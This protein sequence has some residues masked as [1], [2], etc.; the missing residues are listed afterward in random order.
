LNKAILHKSI[1]LLS[2][3]E[4]SI[5]ELQQKLLQREFLLEDISPV[6]DYLLEEDYLNEQR[7][8][9][10]M[11]RLRV[12][13]GYGK[14]YIEN[15]LSQKG[16]NSSQISSANEVQSIDWYLQAELAYSKKFGQKEII[17]QKD[18]VKRIR[19]LQYRGFSTDEIMTVVNAQRLSYKNG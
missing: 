17:G 16:I 4:H 12:N 1:D 9:E 13:K 3:R 14:R 5:Q 15:E 7:Y 2:R 18:K 11:F 8:T 19:F 10:S 6:I